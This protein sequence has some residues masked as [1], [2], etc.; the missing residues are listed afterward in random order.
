MVDKKALMFPSI[1]L[2]HDV[3]NMQPSVKHARPGLAEVGSGGRA[4]DSADSAL[5]ITR[6]VVSLL[7]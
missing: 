2:P 4:S 7:Q 3:G 6:K 5:R 1:V